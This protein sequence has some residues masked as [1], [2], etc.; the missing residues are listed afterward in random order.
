MLMRHTAQQQLCPCRILYTTSAMLSP[1]DLLDLVIQGTLSC[2]VW[3]L[4][5]L[6][7]NIIMESE[8]MHCVDSIESNGFKV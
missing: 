1:T 4:I 2:D 8:L 5:V 7:Y 3:L 6:V